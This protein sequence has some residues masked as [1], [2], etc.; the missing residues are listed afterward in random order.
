M[1]MQNA[2]IPA[3]TFSPNVSIQNGNAFLVRDEDKWCSYLRSIHLRAIFTGVCGFN[4]KS[5][6]Q[7][8]K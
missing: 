6:F 5:G 3:N 4:E 7:L 1:A 2:S 8:L